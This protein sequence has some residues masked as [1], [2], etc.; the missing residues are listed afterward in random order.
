MLNEDGK[1]DVLKLNA[2]MFD[3]SCH[4]Y[5]SVGEKEGQ[6]WSAGMDLM[7]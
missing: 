2:L 1:I 7:K 5:Y 3:N 4:G 6:A